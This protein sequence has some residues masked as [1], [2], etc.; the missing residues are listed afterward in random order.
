[1][2]VHPSNRGLI[3]SI[4]FFYQ[5]MYLA[6]HPKSVGGS[7]KFSNITITRAALVVNDLSLKYYALI[8][9]NTEYCVG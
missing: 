3:I 5:S 9:I 6:D 1:M 4:F 7:L 8:F 2:G